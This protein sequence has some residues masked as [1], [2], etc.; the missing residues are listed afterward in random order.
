MWLAVVP[1]PPLPKMKTNFSFSQAPLQVATFLGFLFAGLAFLAI[2]LTVVARYA[3]IFV[4]GI[5]STIVIVLLLGGIQLISIGIIGEYIGRIYDEVKR[6]PTYLVR[7]RRN[8]AQDAP[9]PSGEAAQ[10]PATR[11]P[12]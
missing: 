9:M 1:D 10:D 7:E 5:S 12:T 8:V 2:P 6:R 4:P 11:V 3:D